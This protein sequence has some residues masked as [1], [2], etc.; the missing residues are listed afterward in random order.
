MNGGSP[1]M[2]NGAPLPPNTGSPMPQ[3]PPG[4]R[5]M[6]SNPG[7][8]PQQMLQQLPNGQMIPPQ[9]SNK[10]DPATL[11]NLAQAQAHSLATPRLPAQYQGPGVN[12]TPRLPAQ[13]TMMSPPNGLSPFGEPAGMSSHSPNLSRPP[14]VAGANGSPS[15]GPKQQLLPP[16]AQPA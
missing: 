5:R 15:Q 4:P 10:M 6:P 2:P 1:Q 16:Q 12:G 7:G 3:P 13:Y 14:S 8:V 11:Q 9:W